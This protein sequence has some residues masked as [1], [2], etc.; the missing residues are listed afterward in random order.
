MNLLLDTHTF[1][2]F[3]KAD[4]LLPERLALAIEDTANTVFISVITGWELAIKQQT[5]KIDLPRPAAE[6]VRD[7]RWQNGFG[8][9]GIDVEDIARLRDL[10]ALHRDPFD[11]IL[12]CQAFR[13]G[14]T[15]LTSD[16]DILR[17]N[18]PHLN[19]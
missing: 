10:P 11:R 13:H 8:I 9:V 17:Y 18:V 16:R 3:I 15:L 5:R 1:L 12:I 6:Y 7:A 4:P 2:W 14:L 19:R